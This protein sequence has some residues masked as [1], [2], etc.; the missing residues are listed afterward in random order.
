M[1]SHE[2]ALLTEFWRAWKQG[3]GSSSRSPS[4]GS[5]NGGRVIFTGTRIPGVVLITPDR[6][7]D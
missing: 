6:R 3:G 2:V 1:S 4:R 7:E 5:C